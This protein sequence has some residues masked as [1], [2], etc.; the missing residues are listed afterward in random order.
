MVLARVRARLTSASTKSLGTLSP[1]PTLATRA[2]ASTLLDSSPRSRVSN[3][4]S[5]VSARVYANSKE[6]PRLQAPR[7]LRRPTEPRLQT[8]RPRHPAEPTIPLRPTEVSRRIFLVAM[9]DDRRATEGVRA[10]EAEEWVRPVLGMGVG[11][12]A[13]MAFTKVRD[14]VQP[15]EVRSSHSPGLHLL[16]RRQATRTLAEP[17]RR[18][19]RL[20]RIRPVRP[21]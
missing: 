6:Q 7:P 13:R 11:L 2:N 18:T 19:A 12:R 8:R 20:A 4:K 15:M 21:A 5:T 14:L 1:D 3:L 17:T 10:R 9:S 16:T